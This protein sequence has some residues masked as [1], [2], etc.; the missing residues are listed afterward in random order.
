LNGADERG[1]LAGLVRERRATVLAGV[2]GIAF[3]VLTV[4]AIVVSGA[5]GGKFKTSDVT[6]YL[7]KGHR[8][9]AIIAAYLGLLGVL[10]LICLLS[11]LREAIGA[12]PDNQHAARIFWGTGLAAAASFAVG[13][14]VAG[15]QVIAHAEGGSGVVIAP[16]VTYLISE[17]GV[18]FVFGSGATLLGF[19]LIALMLGSRVTLPAW[20]R[21]LTLIAGVAGIASLAFFPFF[22]LMIWGIVIGVW[23]L[24]A[25]RGSDPSAM[26]GQPSA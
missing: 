12:A 15:G 14:G 21:W 24:A 8:A 13:W 23:L 22:I 1:T 18:V 6:D 10:G 9:P 19:A 5:P 16:A 20:L 4:V 17:V 25:G 7:A 11:R 2:G 26:A 3:S